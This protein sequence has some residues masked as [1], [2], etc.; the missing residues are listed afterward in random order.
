MANVP[1]TTSAGPPITSTATTGDVATPTKAYIRMA[2][3]WKLVR[4][5]MGG[6]R[7]MR[8]AGKEYLPQYPAEDQTAYDFRLKWTYLYNYYKKAIKALTGKPFGRPLSYP[9]NMNPEFENCLEDFDLQGNDVTI[10]MKN[11]FENALALGVSYGLI[12]YPNTGGQPLTKADEIA[13]VARPYF[14]MIEASDVI[15]WK[16]MQYN[17]IRTLQQVRI[18]QTISVENGSF[19]E[20]E[21]DIVRVFTWIPPSGTAPSQVLWEVYEQTEKGD[22]VSTAR[23]LMAGVTKI[24]LVALYTGQT[25]FMQAEP[26]LLDLAYINVA[27]WQSNSDF[28]HI[29]HLLSVPILYG[30]GWDKDNT[31]TQLALGPNRMLTTPNENAKLTY[32]EHS[33]NAVALLQEY[34]KKIEDEMM[35]MA[36]RLLSD[37]RVGGVTATEITVD[38][39]AAESALKSMVMSLQDAIGQ[40]T[41]FFHEWL[42]IIPKDP[43]DLPDL[44]VNTDF[45][46]NMGNDLIASWLLKA[47]AQGIVT[48][49]TVLCEAKGLGYVPEDLDEDAELEAAA[50]ESQKEFANMNGAFGNPKDGTTGGDPTTTEG[51]NLPTGGKVGSDGGGEDGSTTY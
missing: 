28:R 2:T 29:A 17:G 31:P 27:H 16:T 34:M 33:G 45:G 3:E 44:T 50:E 15:G 11:W 21:K 41:Y 39:A 47:N 20:A 5:L 18:K 19:G 49:K 14:V 13:L 8:E 40:V 30:A 51:D 42:G 23:G 26:P 25:G 1:T 6:T 24:P 10:C 43:E 35:A 36:I 38:V 22:W 12:D 9:D 32:V 46:L 48:K 4:A 7:T 37:K